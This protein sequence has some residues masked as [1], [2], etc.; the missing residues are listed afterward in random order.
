M[1]PCKPLLIALLAAT[2]ASGQTART[3]DLAREI[4]KELAA[5]AQARQAFWGIQIVDLASGRTL[6]ELNPS[7]LFVPAS[8]TKLF[9]GALALSRLGGAFT[10]Q[11]RVM[12][13]AGPDAGGRIRGPL[14]LLGGGDPNL[15]GRTFPYKPDAPPGYPLAAIED[16][17]AQIAAHGV[18]S[19][20]GG[21]IGDDSHYV[22]EPYPEGWAVD[23]P[24]YEYGAP[25][26]ALSV[27]DNMFSLRV[28]PGAKA[29]DPAAVT[30]HPPVEYYAIENR[31]VTRAAAAEGRVSSE[32]DPGSL[33]LRLWGGVPVGGPVRTLEFGIEDPARFAALALRNA[34]T[35]RGVAV[36]GEIA[37]RHLYRSDAPQ[38][39]KQ[40]SSAAEPAG[41]ELARR[42]SVPLLDDLRLTLKA[43]V[44]L[45]AEMALRAVGRE[46][47]G[48][49]SLEA[50]LEEM[51]LFLGETGID[52]D[53]V[54]LNDG[55]GLT[56][57]NLVSPAATVKLLRHMYDSPQRDDWVS[58]LAVGGEDGTLI[59]RLGGAAQGRIFA[60][61]G[62]LSHASAISGYARRRSGGMLVFSILVNNYS[63]SSSAIRGVIDRICTLIVE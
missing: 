9:T 11:T 45:H 23:D 36:A 1:T 44:N 42:T 2:L 56:R 48:V 46:R 10:F 14:I 19:V 33:Q 38:P 60:K 59:G 22:W 17:A 41:V 30:P 37:A 53:S 18:K 62:T 25:V 47:Q 4:P 8:N 21:I 50:G 58:I 3:T 27:N 55:S 49:G 28:A 24:L 29:G 26:S 61:T 35:A 51:R 31:I 40:A 20:E 57:L 43:S 16:L 52:K 7:K 6:Y 32:R 34:L 54:N 15:S 63:D 39:G 5:S 13:A 12:A